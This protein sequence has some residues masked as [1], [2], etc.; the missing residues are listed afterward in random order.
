MERDIREKFLC[1][2]IK[3]KIKILRN[4]KVI[5]TRSFGTDISDIFEPTKLN[6]KELPELPGDISAD[7]FKTPIYNPLV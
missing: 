3:I 1:K 2:W 6:P 5:V 7:T 4:K